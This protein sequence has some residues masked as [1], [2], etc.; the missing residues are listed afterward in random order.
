[1]RKKKQGNFEDYVLCS[2]PGGNMYIEET[3][4]NYIEMMAQEGGEQGRQPNWENYNNF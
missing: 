3:Q 2:C 4:C 1:M